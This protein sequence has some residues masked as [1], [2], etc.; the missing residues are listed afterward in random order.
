M[1]A[2]GGNKHQKPQTIN[3]DLAT[4][5]ADPSNLQA[6]TGRRLGQRRLPVDRSIAQ[7]A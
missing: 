3:G 2:G 4:A 7:S 6:P 1:R 5:F